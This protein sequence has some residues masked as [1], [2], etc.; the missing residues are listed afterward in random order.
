MARRF[1][2]NRPC[3]ARAQTCHRMA[4]ASSIHLQEEQRT[5]TAI[6]YV[7]PVDGGA[8]YKLTFGEHDDFH[9]R[10]SPDGEQIAFISNRPEKAGGCR[11]SRA[12]AVGNL[13]WES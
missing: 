2:V 11:S 3:I 10:W 5:S 6:L 7:L 8:P 4:S 13:R 9:P 1:S 12:L